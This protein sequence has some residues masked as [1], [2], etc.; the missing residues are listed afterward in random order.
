MCESETESEGR[1]AKILM[2]VR[3]A[4]RLPWSVKVV[5]RVENSN[6]VV[7]LLRK[8]TPPDEWS[9]VRTMGDSHG[10]T[11]FSIDLTCY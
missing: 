11:T 1:V 9:R 3:P 5:S 7:G 2:T 8:R 10:T 6:A 4:C